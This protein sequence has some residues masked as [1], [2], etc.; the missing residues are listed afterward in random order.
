MLLLGLSL[1]NVSPL[2]NPCFAQHPFQHWV[3]CSLRVG[4]DGPHAFTADDGTQL[5]WA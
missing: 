4:H 2:R 5:R 3:A 1:R